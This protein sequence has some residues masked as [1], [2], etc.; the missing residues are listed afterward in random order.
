LSIPVCKEV[1][2]EVE[3]RMSEEEGKDWRRDGS[4]LGT[5]RLQWSGSQGAHMTYWWIRKSIIILTLAVS[6]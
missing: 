2:E 6:T 5:R 1:G 4:K 3:V